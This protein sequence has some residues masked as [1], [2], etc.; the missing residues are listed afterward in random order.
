MTITINNQSVSKTV[1]N[2]AVAMA[3]RDGI[4][5]VVF[6]SEVDNGGIKK[7]KHL[8]ISEKT[9]NACDN[10]DELIF[11]TKINKDGNYID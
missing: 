5:V 2:H 9:W 4:T 7:I 11:V 8:V 10:K 3:I 1:L 6:G